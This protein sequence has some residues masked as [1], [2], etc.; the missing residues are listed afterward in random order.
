MPVAGLQTSFVQGLLSLQLGGVPGVQAPLWQ[1][2]TPLQGLPSEQ[3]IPFC[4]GVLT[5][6]PVTG[7]QESVVQ[8]LLSSQL[9]GACWQPRAASQVSVVQ[10]LE[11]S[12]LIS[13]CVQLPVVG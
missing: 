4:T 8:G 3:L 5:H 10:A 9:R 1:V 7:S 12:Q 6:V 2:S 13:V 11:S